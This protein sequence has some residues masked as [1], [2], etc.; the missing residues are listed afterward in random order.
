MMNKAYRREMRRLVKDLV[1]M[2]DSYSLALTLSVLRRVERSS[3][4]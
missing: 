3:Q 1:K 2:L 4:C